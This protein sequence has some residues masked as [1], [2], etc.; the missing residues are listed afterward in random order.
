[1]T[2]ALLFP[3]QGAQ[4]VGMGAALRADY[5]AARDLYDRA[6]EVLGYD[7]AALCENGPAEKLN[8]TDVSQPALY[9]SGYAALEKLKAEHPEALA[10]VSHVA[11]LSLGE[12]TALAFA[13]AFDFED[14]LR[15]VQARGRAMQAAAEATS[16]GMVSALLL[17]R[18]AVQGVRD[19]AAGDEVLEL[20]NFLCPGNTVLSGE[21]AAIARAIEEIEKAGGRPIP[22]AV[23]GAFHTSL[24]KPADERLAAALDAVEIRPPKVPVVSNVDA[25]PHTDP[26]EIRDLLVRQ[27]LAPVRWEDS[28][29]AM[30]AAGVDRFF[31]VGTGRV[32]TGLLKRIDRKTPCTAVGD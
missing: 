15:V 32:L 4:T 6:A 18:D 28:I 26:A 12:Y 25:A 7:L 27:V 19:A 5:P 17:D 16:S 11:G 24:M 2:T 3:G 10:D 9:V 13:E 8:A 1:M 20:A 30:M 21:S 31:E 14:G 22:L 29:R 23:A